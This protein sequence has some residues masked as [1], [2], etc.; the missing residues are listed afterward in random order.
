MYILCLFSRLE[1]TKK[2]RGGDLNGYFLSSMADLTNADFPLPL[3]PVIKTNVSTNKCLV[4]LFF[5][6]Q[7]K[8]I[9]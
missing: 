6:N 3:C 2:K 7:K 8:I 4:F 5:G 1:S 9:L